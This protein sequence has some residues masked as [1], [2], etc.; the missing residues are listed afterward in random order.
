MN[1]SKGPGVAK[2]I[3][4]LKGDKRYLLE[5]SCTFE[6]E[7]VIMRC[8]EIYVDGKLKHRVVH[9]CKLYVDRIDSKRSFNTF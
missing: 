9:P 4:K 1:I 7:F 2:G 5:K 6:K 8:E 3:Y